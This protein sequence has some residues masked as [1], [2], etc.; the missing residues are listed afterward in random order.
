MAI[1]FL[2]ALLSGSAWA[3][4]PCLSSYPAIVS[5][6]DGVTIGGQVYYSY[7]QTYGLSSCAA[8]D[9]NLEPFC[10]TGDPSDTPGW[11]DDSWCYVDKNNCDKPVTESHYFAGVDLYFSYFSCF[12]AT[13]V[14]VLCWFHRGGRIFTRKSCRNLCF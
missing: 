8:H 10:N 7:P 5:P 4:C 1:V 2:L 14:N 6:A 11:C 3:A 13:L 12:T 9:L